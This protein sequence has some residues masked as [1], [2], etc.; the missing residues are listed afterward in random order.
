MSHPCSHLCVV[1]FQQAIST[2]LSTPLTDLLQRLI[3]SFVLSFFHTCKCDMSHT[4]SHLCVG[5][6]WLQPAFS[7][8]LS[9]PLHTDLLQRLIFIF[10]LF[11][12]HTG[13]CDMSHPC[14][15]LCV[16]LPYGGF[17]C[18]CEN[19]SHFLA[20]NGFLCIKKTGKLLSYLWEKFSIQYMFVLSVTDFGWV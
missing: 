16:D 6:W 5:L 18:E 17:K 7:T 8:W 9:T 11:F 15:Q 4:C 10:L 20:Q 3:L 19:E 2:W 13:R 14:S 12:F 1:R